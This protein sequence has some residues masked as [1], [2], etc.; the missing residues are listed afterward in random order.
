LSVGNVGDSL[1]WCLAGF[2]YSLF[3]LSLKIDKK[4]FRKNETPF[5]P[6]HYVTKY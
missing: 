6:T 2:L 3:F 4:L 5:C 1:R